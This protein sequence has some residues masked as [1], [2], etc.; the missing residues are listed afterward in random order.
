MGGAGEAGSG[1][2]ERGREQTES[3]LASYGI[4]P[5]DGT[6]HEGG[7]FEEGSVVQ[8]TMRAKS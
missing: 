3:D 2:P 6:Y 8:V 7:P 5:G 1:E 4:E